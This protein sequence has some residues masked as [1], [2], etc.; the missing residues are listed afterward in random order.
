MRLGEQPETGL[1]VTMAS[2]K[3]KAS[4]FAEQE[5]SLF[6]IVLAA[7]AEEAIGLALTQPEQAALLDT[8]ARQ[9]LHQALVGLGCTPDMLANGTL[10]VTVPALG[11]AQ[12]QATLAA[13]AALL[14]KERWPEAVVSMATGR[15]TINGRTAVGEVVELAARSLRR[16]GRPAMEPSAAF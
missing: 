12:D 6:S 9:A 13:R 16:A 2:Q 10:V 4:G 11:S 7:P 8:T 1:A 15:G 5:Q 14:I 3:P